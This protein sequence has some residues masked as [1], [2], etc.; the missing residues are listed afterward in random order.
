MNAIKKA[1]AWSILAATMPI[2][3]DVASD[4]YANR[5]VGASWLRGAAILSGAGI[6]AWAIRAASEQA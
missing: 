1:A 2:V 4:P 3:V 6:F 5:S